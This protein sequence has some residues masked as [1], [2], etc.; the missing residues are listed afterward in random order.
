V[1]ASQGAIGG[2]FIGANYIQSTNWINLTTGW[3][4]NNDGTGQIGGLKVT[5]TGIESSNFV[6]GTSG[7]RM[8]FDGQVE[9]LNLFARGNIQATSLNAATGTFSGT[10]T[11][12][13]IDAVRAI[14]I[15]GDAVIVPRRGEYTG[16]FVGD[17]ATLFTLPTITYEKPGR[18]VLFF[19]ATVR[20]IGHTTGNGRLFIRRN[21][22]NIFST[23][24]FT[25]SLIEF[26]LPMRS[27]QEDSLLGSVDYS[28]FFTKTSSEGTTSLDVEMTVMGLTA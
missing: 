7:L 24:E 5:A 25:L 18:A 22:S 2:A 16:N 11:S 23:P 13:A 28:L 8:N 21:G 3:R 19:R 27:I 15:A 17:N 10:L 1:F 6:S 9:M 20:E 26:V 12:D 14:N 4:L